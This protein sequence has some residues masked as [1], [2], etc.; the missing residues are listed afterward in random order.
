MP[1]FSSS[2]IDRFEY[3]PEAR[4]SERFFKEHIRNRTG[5]AQPVK[6]V[7]GDIDQ[8]WPLYCRTWASGGPPQRTRE[9]MVSRREWHRGCLGPIATTTQPWGADI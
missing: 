6:N 8:C 3:D 7:L 1:L 5:L 2:G 4:I 9:L